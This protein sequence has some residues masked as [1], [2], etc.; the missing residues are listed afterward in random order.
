MVINNRSG[1]LPPQPKLNIKIESTYS[2]VFSGDYIS[3]E[4]EVPSTGLPGI[5]WETCQTMQLPNNWGYSRPVGF[6]TYVD[7]QHQLVDVASKGGNMLLNIGPSDSG[8]IPPQALGCLAK[9]GDWMKV[10]AGSIHGITASPFERLP[11]E[12]RCTRRGNRLYLHVFKWPDNGELVLPAANRVTRAF[13]LE[14]PDAPL[15]IRATTRGTVIE[16]PRV[17]PDPVDSVI[18]VE[19]GGEPKPLSSPEVVSKG[20]KP[21]VSSVWHGREDHLNPA[22]ITDGNP[23]T[24]WAPEE[25]A[26]EATITLSLETTKDVCEVVLSDAPYGRVTGFELD[27]RIGTTWRKIHTGAT[28]GNS[29]T[30]ATDTI[31]TDALRLRILGATDTPTLAEFQVLAAPE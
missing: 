12:G 10:N 5:D 17:A 13:L 24:I 31:R 3:P 15:S 6:R 16:I 30:I 9:F 27:A 23:L 7:L 4:G 19:I 20:V 25:K 26:R 18:S 2:Y 29:R 1:H 8:S 14:S 21:E 28:I 11:F 22:H